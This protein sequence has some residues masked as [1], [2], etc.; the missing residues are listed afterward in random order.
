MVVRNRSLYRPEYFD[1]QKNENEGSI[2]LKSAL[3]QNIYLFLSIMVLISIILFI[4]FAEYTRRETLKG[5][6]SPLGGVVKV[7]SND[8]GYIDTIFVKE[9]DKVQVSTPLYKIRTERFDGSG[10]AVKKRILTSI[11]NQ[12]QLLFERRIQESN[13]ANFNTQSLNDDIER[14]ES[15][16]VIL[17]RVLNLSNKEFKLAQKL[18][19]KQQ[20]LLKKNFMS[21]IDYQKQQLDLITTESQTEIHTLNLQRLLREK[22]QLLTSKQNIDIELQITLK[23][24]DRQLETITQNKVEFLYQSDTQV[25]SPIEGIIASILTEK[26]HAVTNGQPLLVIVPKENKTFVELYAPSRSIGFMKV[27]QEVKLRFDAFPYE[28]FGVQSGI[29]TGVSKSAVAPEMIANQSL[30]NSIKV[31][32]LYQV[33][34]EL[35]KP[36]ITVYGKEERYVSGMTVTADVELDTR[37]IY[38][39]ILEPLYTI[40]GRI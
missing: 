2:L 34:V 7:Q 40:Q 11:D 33:R 37:K 18:V 16:I 6:V 3:N 1:A 8:I 24:I 19:N 32:G 27:G 12:Y 38:E 25:I 14:L 4:I 9:G 17:R 13:K 36:T 10:I 28:K 5:I 20:V 15:E 39:W 30:I 26:G 23:D 21:E 31:E 22:E 35:T 29:I